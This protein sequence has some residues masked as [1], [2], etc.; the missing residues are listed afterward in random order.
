MTELHLPFFALVCASFAHEEL[1]KLNPD[2][3][4]RDSQ[5]KRYGCGTTPLNAMLLSEFLKEHRK[6]H[7]LEPNASRE[8]RNIATKQ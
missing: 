7:E 8:E 1:Q 4:V 6:V 5:G 2:L 3:I